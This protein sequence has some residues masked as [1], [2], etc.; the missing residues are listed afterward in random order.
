MNGISYPNS[1]VTHCT[2]GLQHFMNVKLTILSIL[3]NIQMILL[4]LFK[5]AALPK[6]IL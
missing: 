6:I 5:Q 1:T 2:S 3:G 4:I